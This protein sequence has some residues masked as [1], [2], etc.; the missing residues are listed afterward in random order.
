MGEMTGGEIISN[1]F[2]LYS[3]WLYRWRQEHEDDERSD[4]ELTEVYA[5]NEGRELTDRIMADQMG[6]AR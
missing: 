2:D 5:S 3:A 6:G 1:A 4:Y